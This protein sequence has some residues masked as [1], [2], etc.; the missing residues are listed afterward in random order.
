M[1]EPRVPAAES[2]F[3]LMENLQ[4]HGVPVSLLL[5]PVIPAVND[6]EIE[7]IVKRAAQSGAEHAAFVLLRLPHE[8]KSV[9]RDWLD[10][11][12]PDRAEHVMSL[13]RQASGGRDYDNR[14]GVRQTGRGPYAD[15][16]K[17]RFEVACNRHG[18]AR[19]RDR[20]ALDTARFEHPGRRQFELSFA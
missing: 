9:F 4:R 16:I 6:M 3:Q 2:R 7:G 12:M 20:R 18:I 1:L 14:F 11:H 17:Q 19:G 10:A 8:L 5:A 13:V 15:M